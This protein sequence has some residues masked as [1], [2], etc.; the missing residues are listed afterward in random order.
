MQGFDTA[1][2]GFDIQWWWGSKYHGKG[3]W[4]SMSRGSKY[5][6][7]GVRRIAKMGHLIRGLAI[8]AS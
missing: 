7:Q 8:D 6:R 5:H 2:I 4:Y 3:L 1:L